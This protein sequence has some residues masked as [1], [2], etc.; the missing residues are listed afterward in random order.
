MLLHLGNPNPSPTTQIPPPFCSIFILQSHA[1]SRS[2]FAAKP[3]FKFR[4]SVSNSAPQIASKSAIERIAEKLRSLGYVEE[5][6]SVDRVK[7]GKESA[8]EIFVPLPHHLP[9][10]RVGHTIDTSW[11]T[12]ENPVPKVGSGGAVVR[13]NELNKVVKREKWLAKEDVVGRKERE[14]RVPTLAELSLP[15]EELGR[16]REIGKRI[17]MKLKVGKAGITEGIVN[18]IHERWRR[19]EVVRLTCEDIC[20]LNMKRTHDLLEVKSQNSYFS[21]ILYASYD[22]VVFHFLVVVCIDTVVKLT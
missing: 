13:V 20:R 10:Q 11:S 16:L 2:L 12:P 15:V 1:V 14:E 8:G 4:C 21:C 17:K 19:S 6:K 9:K 5:V 7:Y 18:G 22:S 3:K